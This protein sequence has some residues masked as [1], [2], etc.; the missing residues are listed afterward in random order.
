MGGL[1]ALP[2]VYYLSEVIEIERP[3]AEVSLRA[4][5]L[6]LNKARR[7]LRM[8]GELNVR[9]TS[10][11]ELQELNRRFRRKNKPTDVLSFPSAVPGSAG[12]IAIAVEIA[13]QN[14]H[15]LGHSLTTELKILILHAL[16]HLAGYNHESD[17]GEMTAKE[18]QLRQ[19]LGLPVGL[20]E[21]TNSHSHPVA[22]S[23]RQAR[24]THVAQDDR[25]LRPSRP[26]LARA[27]Q[28][29]REGHRA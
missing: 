14:A 4:L 16:L 26:R 6:F 7:P 18:S 24:G 21:R 5:S 29:K 11:R 1:A 3:S 20:I 8:E 10:A 2:F 13:A 12:D 17:S 25:A 19:D 15:R 9:I 27:R 22:K 23:R 28:K